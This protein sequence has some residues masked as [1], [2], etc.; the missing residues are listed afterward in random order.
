MTE[1]KAHAD[2]RP[3]SAAKRWL[4]CPASSEVMRMY[5]NAPS[6]AS[7]KGDYEHEV[8]EDTIL[9]GVVPKNVSH[10]LAESMEFLLSYVKQRIQAMNKPLVLVESKVDIPETGEHGYLDIGLISDKEIEVI[11]HKSGYVPV[12]V[13]MN[14]QLMLYLLGLIAKYG[15]RKK[16]TITVHQPYYDHI[17]GP[18]RKYDVSSEDIEWLR[19]E[20]KY[21]LDNTD[22]FKAGKHCK[23][24]YCPHRGSCMSFAQ[25]TLTDASLGWH[26]SEINALSDDLLAEALDHAETLAGYR[27]ELRKE[28]MRRILNMDRH[29]N[30]YKIVKGRKQRSVLEPVKLLNTVADKLGPEYAIRM[31][32]DISCFLSA[33][34]FPIANDD[35]TVTKFLGTAKQIED[36]IKQYSRD[37]KLPRGGWKSVY[38]NTVG[39]FIRE[40]N[41]G[42]TLEKAIDGR[43]AHRRGSEFTALMQH[44]PNPDLDLTTI[45]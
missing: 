5:P 3:P 1:V 42:L 30:G 36:V 12:G 43:P 25:Y 39:E 16:Y 40:T 17:D 18:L 41:S 19:R 6:E 11:D 4:S 2:K 8:M 26:T 23:E 20:I 7:L 15:E 34:S 22:E 32:P 29:V 38:D 9:F 14:P 31:L 35:N 10:D 13:Y 21:S 28:A 44:T 24:T 45:I 27:D 33:L 37:N